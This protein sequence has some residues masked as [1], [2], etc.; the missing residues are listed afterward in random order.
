MNADFNADLF[1]EIASLYYSHSHWRFRW[2]FSSSSK[3]GWSELD[4][5]L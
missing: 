1:A 4:S 3:P 2:R 5:R